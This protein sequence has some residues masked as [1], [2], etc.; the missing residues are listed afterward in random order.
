MKEIGVVI[1]KNDEHLT[2]QIE[3]CSTCEHSSTCNLIDKNY[4][5]IIP[6]D[7]QYSEI[8]ICDKLILEFP[9]SKY[10]YMLFIVFILP[11]IFIFII[12]FLANYFFY[13]ELLKISI[14]LISLIIIFLFLFFKKNKNN[15]YQIKIR[16]V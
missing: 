15:K 14:S 13:N 4:Q 5:I 7:K 16:K 11:I 1:N 2:I 10:F 6:A 9:D 8:N 12:Y 3:R